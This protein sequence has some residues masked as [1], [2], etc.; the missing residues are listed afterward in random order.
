MEGVEGHALV[1]GRVLIGIDVGGT[2]VL[3]SALDRSNPAISLAGHR[4]DT[5]DGADA[6]VDAVTEMVRLLQH[7]L[8]DAGHPPAVAVGVGMP[9]L[10]ALDGSMRFATHLPEVADLPMARV[11]SERL[12]VPVTLDNDA[13]CAVVAEATIGAAVGRDE[14]LL[15]TLGT[16]IGGGILTGGRLLRGARGFAGEPGHMMVDRKGV[17]CPC[18][19]RGCWERYASGSG[20]GQLGRDAAAEG[21]APAV[22][23]RVDTVA[24]IRGEHVVDAASAGDPGA[25]AVM[26]EFGWWVA[27]GLA[28]LVN[29][30]DPE[31]IVLGGGLVDA[32]DLL[33]EPVRSSYDTLTLGGVTNGAPPIVPARLGSGAGAI[34]A[35]LVA[36][37]ER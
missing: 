28:N 27:A 33:L 11:L 36:D 4:L 16:G 24:D 9:A 20:L 17:A 34:G 37:A 30:L 7:M 5:P 31:V 35:A 10:V 1:K 19:R 8:A 2:K 3:G 18:G 21:R 12:G 14:V 25:L 6:I 15:V 32:G 13:N 22:L 26:A 29:V 23:G